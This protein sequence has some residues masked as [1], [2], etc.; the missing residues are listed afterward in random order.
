[1]K[2]GTAA[3]CECYLVA[4][5]GQEEGINPVKGQTTG[6]AS[7]AYC[8]EI[9]NLMRR[10]HSRKMV[11]QESFE[12]RQ[13]RGCSTGPRKGFRFNGDGATSPRVL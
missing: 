13:G 3:A 11:K 10:D 9:R 8:S 7:A 1:V 12:T 4:T 6:K 2:G 5:A